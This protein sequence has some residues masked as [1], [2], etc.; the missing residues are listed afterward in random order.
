[1]TVQELAGK[2]WDYVRSVL[3]AHGADKEEIGL[4]GFH[5]VTK[6]ATDMILYGSGSVCIP[7]DGGDPYHVPIREIITK[8]VVCRENSKR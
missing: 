6:A 5:Y 7:E 2:H 3:E 4:I 1:M 8:E